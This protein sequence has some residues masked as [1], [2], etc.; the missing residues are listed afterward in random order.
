MQCPRCQHENRSQARF[1]EE[2]GAPTNPSGT[3]APSPAEL[4]RALSEAHERQ[5]VT[6][7]ILR[8]ISRCQTDIQPVFDAIAV[9]ALD[10]CRA[11]TGWVYRFDGEHDVRHPVGPRDR[12]RAA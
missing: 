1:C 9:K 4:T 3:P 6:G 10:L 12:E 2:C 7:E 8:V 5:A 11:T